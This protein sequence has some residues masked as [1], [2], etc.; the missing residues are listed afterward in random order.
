MKNNGIE[1]NCNV[2]LVLQKDDYGCKNAGE[3]GE[4]T[5]HH[6]ASWD[7]QGELDLMIVVVQHSVCPFVQV[8][9][10]C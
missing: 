9:D 7:G 5:Q 6:I 4:Q 2:L 8:V 10:A 1:D 3:K